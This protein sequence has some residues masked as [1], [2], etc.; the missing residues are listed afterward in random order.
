M[1]GAVHLALV[2][3]GIADLLTQLE[4]GRIELTR[5]SAYGPDAHV[6][7]RAPQPGGRAGKSTR[8]TLDISAKDDHTYQRC[9]EPHV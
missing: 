1:A 4:S 6:R 7:D 2:G 9:D 3:G 5:R 8:K